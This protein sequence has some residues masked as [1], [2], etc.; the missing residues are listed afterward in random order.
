M[1]VIVCLC[2]ALIHPPTLY[3]Q[4]DCMA[5]APLEVDCS[6]GTCRGPVTLIYQSSAP[7]SGDP[8]RECRH[9]IDRY[10]NDIKSIQGDFAIGAAPAGLP[11]ATNITDLSRFSQ[12]EE[13]TGSLTVTSTSSRGL[14]NLEQLSNLRTIGGDFVIGEG[15]TRGQSEGTGLERVGNLPALTTV[16]RRFVVSQNNRE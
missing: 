2:G 13:V 10:P 6:G 11:S 15:R 4:Q 5:N 3:A 16:G 14:S 1:A 8:R 12:L 9:T 7:G